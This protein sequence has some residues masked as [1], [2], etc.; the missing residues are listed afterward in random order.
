MATAFLKHALLDD[1]DYQTHLD[2][3]HFNPE[4]QNGQ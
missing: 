4:K 2:C 3:L 1:H